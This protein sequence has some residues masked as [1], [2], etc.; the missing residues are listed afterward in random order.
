MC[1]PGPSW[2]RPSGGL[3]DQIDDGR[4]GLLVPPGDEVA[5]A[6]ALIRLLEDAELRSA[7]GRAANERLHQEWSVPVIAG[8]TLEVYRDATRARS[9]R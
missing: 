6:D 2:P 1:T 3:T 8:Q 5:L 9:R 4:T 7:M